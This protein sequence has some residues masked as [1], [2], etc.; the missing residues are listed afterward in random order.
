MKEA[1]KENV[2]MLARQGWTVDEIAKALKL[3]IE[4]VQL[5]LETA[6]PQGDKTM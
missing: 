6:P 5:I 1:L 2:I 4:E 3:S